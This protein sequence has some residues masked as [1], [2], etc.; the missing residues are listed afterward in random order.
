MALPLIIFEIPYIKQQI[1]INRL[2]ILIASLLP[3]VI[4]KVFLFFGIGDG[5]FIFHSLFFVLI[6]TLLIVLLNK[7]LL[8]AKIEDRIKNSYSIAFSF[9]IGSFI[10]L[11][12]DLPTIPLFYP[13]IEYKKYYYF[14]HFGAAVNSWLIEFLSNPILIFSEIA[15]FAMLLFILIHNKL[16]NLKRIWEYFTTTQ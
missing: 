13:F 1:Q 7:L 16:Y 10:H 14:P 6:T 15:G 3:D 5:R 11:L 12:L 2:T 8:Y 9:F 4:D